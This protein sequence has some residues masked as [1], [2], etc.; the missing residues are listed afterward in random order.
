MGLDPFAVDEEEGTAGVADGALVTAAGLV[1]GVTVKTTKNGKMMAFISLEDQTGTVECILFPQV[2]E[3]HRSVLREDEK[4]VVAGRASVGDEERGRIIADT[5]VRFEDTPREIWIR[6]ADRH[7]YARE[8]DALLGMLSPF[9]G[10]S[11]VVIF[12]AKERAYKKLPPQHAV[13]W[14][15]ELAG[16][17]KDRY[18]AS[19]VSVVEK[20]IEKPSRTGYNRS[21]NGTRKG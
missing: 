12:L 5:L 10:P 4:L 20:S 16:K 18:G 21:V 1:T 7:A 15:P 11:P 13:R 3:K 9:K 14:S 8:E 6:F 19:N 17:L 2:F